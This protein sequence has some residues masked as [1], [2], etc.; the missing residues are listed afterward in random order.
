MRHGEVIFLEFMIVITKSGAFEA[1]NVSRLYSRKAA[2]YIAAAFYCFFLKTAVNQLSED[3]VVAGQ[4]CQVDPV[5]GN[6]ITAA[7]IN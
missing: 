5:Q 6:Q 7:S 4:V 2:A 3:K 1:N